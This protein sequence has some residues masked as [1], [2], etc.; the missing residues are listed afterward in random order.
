MARC[1]PRPGYFR[2]SA[3]EPLK[4]RSSDSSQS[5]LDGFRETARLPFPIFA[6]IVYRLGQE[7]LN[8][9]S[10]V[11]FPV[12]APNFPSFPIGNEGFLRAVQEAKRS[13]RYGSQAY[14]HIPD[15][16]GMRQR[17]YYP[18]TATSSN[19]TPSDTRWTIRR[20]MSASISW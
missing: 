5:R 11:R 4:L 20:S 10:G 7:I 14:P 18:L 3:S 19:S 15:A 6:L 8:L 17:P 12:G 13:G 9:Q 16:S 1:V 2:F